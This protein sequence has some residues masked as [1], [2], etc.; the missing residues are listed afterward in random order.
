MTDTTIHP[1]ADVTAA[2]THATDSWNLFTLQKGYKAT[3]PDWQTS[4]CPT[5]SVLLSGQVVGNGAEYALARFARDHYLVLG[6]Y[7]DQ[8]PKFDVTQPGR[9][10]LV[11]RY[12]GVWVELWH[13]NTAA[14]VSEPAIPVFSR[15]VRPVAVQ[16][17]PKPEPAPAAPARSLISRASDR[18]PFT[19][20]R[21]KETTTR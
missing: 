15:R 13:P 18:L 7:G 14:D 12:G 4:A 16:T 6:Q 10:V 1:A 2:R 17:T 9:T 11:W 3:V 19:R 5:G 21:H 8:R 20:N